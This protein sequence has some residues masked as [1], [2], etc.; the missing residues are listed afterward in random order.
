MW[1]PTIVLSLKWTRDNLPVP[2]PST[3]T[4]AHSSKKDCTPTVCHSAVYREWRVGVGGDPAPE[5]WAGCCWSPPPRVLSRLQGGP[6]ATHSPARYEPDAERGFCCCFCCCFCVSRSPRLL[7]GTLWCAGWRAQSLGAASSLPA[8]EDRPRVTCFS[9]SD[10]PPPGCP[11]SSAGLSC[12]SGGSLLS[13][14]TV[15]HTFL[16]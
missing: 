2:R 5:E 8:F 6:L 11:P 1:K 15:T 4:Q 14:S 10:H 16:P 13:V 3:T 9:Q 12:L 7:C